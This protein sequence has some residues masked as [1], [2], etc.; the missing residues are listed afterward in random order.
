MKGAKGGKRDRIVSYIFSQKNKEE[1]ETD[2][3]E[4]IKSIDEKTN[5]NNLISKNDSQPTL[6]KQPTVTE[7]SNNYDIEP[8]RKH[9]VVQDETSFIGNEYEEQE[10]IKSIDEKTNINNLTSSVDSQPTLE[11]QPTVTEE[12]N[13]YDS[14][15]RQR[16]FAT[17]NETEQ[18][19]SENQTGFTPVQLSESNNKNEEK[20]QT[21]KDEYKH[22]TEKAEIPKGT[23]K[24]VEENKKTI[25]ISTTIGETKPDENEE[26]LEK[27]VIDALERIIREDINELEQ[28][29]YELEVLKQ[30]EED[31]ALTKEVEKIKK[32]LED[33]ISKFE[34]IRDIYYKSISEEDLT[35]IDDDELYKLVT[36]YKEN[37]KDGT[38]NVMEIVET[39][40]RVVESYVSLIE[41]ISDLEKEKDKLDNKID[42]KLDKFQI[43]DDEFEE[44]KKD[45]ENIEE[46]NTTIES[47]NN[48]QDKILK[49]L[50]DK[51][52]RSENAST[53]VERTVSMVPHLNRLIQAAIM[54]SISRRIPP[55]PHGNLIKAGLMIGA[56]NMAAHF[57]TREESEKQI[58]T[59]KYQDFSKDL[60]EI[61]NDIDD[62]VLKIDDA[63]NNIALIKE[64]FKKNCEEYK[65]L[66]PEYDE[67]MKKMDKI[68]KELKEKQDI[69]KKHSKDFDEMLEKNNAKVKRLEKLDNTEVVAA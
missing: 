7:E 69:A 4:N 18:V 53:K 26:A 62:I 8:R 19:K 31:E 68:E 52:K 10:N 29:Q 38:H 63:F 5:I 59:I 25:V 51:M 20:S 12:N 37:Y 13:N 36:E 33:L 50:E 35:K 55:T 28:I 1:K 57:I 2:E 21:V 61:G 67:F 40:L 14:E 48:E 44:M 49:E 45:Y 54:I 11:K 47:F 34:K 9:F 58:T 42:E 3:Q 17:H 39:E 64:N 27:S 66:I 32:R 41:Q 43:R 65:G 22:T 16:I 15:P 6:E 23:V 60:K 24:P 56:I 46:I 30:Q